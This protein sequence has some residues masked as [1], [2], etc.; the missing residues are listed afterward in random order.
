MNAENLYRYELKRLYRVLLLWTAA[1]LLV[2]VLPAAT[3]STS[4]GMLRY[5]EMHTSF[6]TVVL[7]CMCSL[8]PATALRYRTQR[9]SADL[10]YSLPMARERILG[11]KYLAGYTVCVAAFTVGFWFGFAALMLRTGGNYYWGYFF[12]QYLFDLIG[13]YIVYAVSSFLYSRANTSADGIAFLVIFNLLGMSVSSLLG[14]FFSVTVE[15]FSP[16]GGLS[17][18]TAFFQDMTEAGETTLLS[19]DYAPWYIAGACLY[20]ALAVAATVAL[21]RT[22]RR[23]STENCGQI[24]ESPFGYRV[25][26]PVT[27]VCASAATFLWNRAVT[28]PFAVLFDSVAI[29]ISYVAMVAYRRSV[30]IGWKHFLVWL[31]SLLAGGVLAVLIHMCT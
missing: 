26:Y 29:L 5:Y 6:C 12:P 1:F 8:M 25:M 18:V 19:Q 4:D 10:Y 24:S 3:S 14:E 11:V 9:E 17:M 16:W 22:E 20:A 2:Y 30:W 13:G 27:V 21:F 31:A 23:Y 7:V 28:I 15:V